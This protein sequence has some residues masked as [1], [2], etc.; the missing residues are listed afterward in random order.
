MSSS[1]L[2]CKQFSRLCFDINLNA[3]SIISDLKNQHNQ[4]KERKKDI[5]NNNHEQNKHRDS[6]NKRKGD[7]RRI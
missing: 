3:L 4:D 1:V 2:A 6:R 5:E 7:P